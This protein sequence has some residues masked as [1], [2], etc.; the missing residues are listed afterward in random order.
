MMKT[1]EESQPREEEQRTESRRMRHEPVVYSLWSCAIELNSA[2]NDEWQH[3]HT[4]LPI[5]DAY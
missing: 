2:R 3:A 5:G 1:V 4:L